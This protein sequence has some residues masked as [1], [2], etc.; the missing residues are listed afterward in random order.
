MTTS[1]LGLL[2]G[3]S[4]LLSSAPTTAAANPPA[5]HDPGMS[6]HRTSASQEFERIDQPLGLKL[7]IT[8]AGLGLIGLELW[9]FLVSRPQS[10]QARSTHH[11]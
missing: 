1:L 2:T 9:W 6:P 11:Q 8:A 10:Q 3:F 5:S 7:G 4:L